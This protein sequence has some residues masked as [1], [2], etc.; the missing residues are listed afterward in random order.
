[1]SGG[2]FR[3]KQVEVE[4][5][6]WTGDNADEAGRLLL[7]T[8]QDIGAALARHG[9]GVLKGDYIVRDPDGFL[10][11]LSEPT[12]LDRYEPA[13]PQPSSN[14]EKL[15]DF[16][17]ELHEEEVAHGSTLMKVDRLEKA[18]RFYAEQKGIGAV[19]ASDGGMKARE[20]LREE[21]P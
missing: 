18:L 19:L 15:R 16:E 20:A 3:K 2:R 14:E 6:Q 4:A 10:S 21:T 7:F 12:F 17:Y 9:L 5:V 8:G 1:M 13:D 11:V